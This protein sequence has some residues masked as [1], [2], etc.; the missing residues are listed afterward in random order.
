MHRMARLVKPDGTE[1][2]VDLHDIAK[3]PALAPLMSHEGVL[4][5][6]RQ[7]LV[8]KLDPIVVPE[9]EPEP[10]PIVITPDPIP[11]PEPTPEPEPEPEP[12]PER[13]GIIQTILE[14]LRRLFKI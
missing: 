7:K 1:E 2:E 9:P 10:D 3:D 14:L 5:Y 4:K 11:E 6:L 13:K 8:P 12:Q